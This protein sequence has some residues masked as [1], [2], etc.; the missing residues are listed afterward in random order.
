MSC[1]RTPYSAPNDRA[2]SNLSRSSYL[3]SVVRVRHSTIIRRIPNRA[4]C[5][6]DTACHHLSA[7]LLKN[8]YIAIPNIESILYVWSVKNLAKSIP[9]SNNVLYLKIG[10]AYAEFVFSKHVNVSQIIYETT[11]PSFAC[12]ATSSS[13][14]QIKNL[15]PTGTF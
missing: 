9:Q 3:S 14:R 5:C 10:A 8:T 15:P 2:R 1:S 6:Y 7:A 13:H 12:R 11:N 4:T